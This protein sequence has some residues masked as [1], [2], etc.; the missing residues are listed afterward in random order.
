[1]RGPV[2]GALALAIL[3]LAGCDAIEKIP[4]TPREAAR[5]A[6]PFEPA[7]RTPVEREGTQGQ[8]WELAVVSRREASW[9]DAD[10]ALWSGLRHSCPDGQP[11]TTLD[12]EPAESTEREIDAVHPEGT[13][14]RRRVLCPPPAEFEMALPAGTTQ[15]QAAVIF[16]Q[17]FNE[18]NEGF[19]REPTVIPLRFSRF[20][21]PYQALADALGRASLRKYRECPQGIQVERMLL[22]ML[23]PAAQDEDRPADGYVGL[24]ASC[25]RDAEE[26]LA[27][28]FVQPAPE[29]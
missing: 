11:A 4:L 15:A 14:F 27:L 3:C 22:G 1:M 5:M 9:R 28:P 19:P 10:R 13:V 25:R 6:R 8:V 24:L 16:G 26:A 2:R 7:T 20:V 12:S 21:A 17:R 18:G 23:P 29:E